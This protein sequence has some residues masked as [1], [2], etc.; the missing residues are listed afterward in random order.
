MDAA[1][2][3]VAEYG[4]A[5]TS[6]RAIIKASGHRNNSAIAYH[7]GTRDGLIEAVFHRGSAPP[8]R[9]RRARLDAMRERGV[10][11]DLRTLAEL[12]VWPLAAE[13]GRLQPRNQW[14]RYNERMLIERPLV[15]VEHVRD[16]IGSH[17][18]EAP[19]EVALEIYDLMADEPRL[20]DTSI[21]RERVALGVRFVFAALAAWERDV[22]GGVRE[23]AGIDE[24]AA[25]VIE[26]LLG[27]LVAPRGDV[28]ARTIEPWSATPG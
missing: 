20:D 7:F 26:M 5:G 1:E 28:A 10:K 14:A 15:F 25:D 23:S 13:I 11:P 22:A 2:L 12:L 18:G 4:S 6:D 3:L 8:N 19:I 24:F 16:G 17:D 21:G 9:E 27:L